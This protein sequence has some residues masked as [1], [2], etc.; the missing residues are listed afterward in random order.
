MSVKT[1]LDMA[2]QELGY[3]GKISDSQLDNFT[4][5][6]RGKYTKYGAEYGSYFNQRSSFINSDWCHS[7]VSYLARHTGQAD[8]T[9]QHSAV[10]YTA[11]CPTGF[12]WFRQRGRGH[13]RTS[14]YT[15]VEGDIAYFTWSGIWKR[16]DG[17]YNSDHVGI[18]TK[19]AN[20]QVTTA[21]GNTNNSMSM[22]KIRPINSTDFLGFGHPDYLND[23]GGDEDMTLDQFKALYNQMTDEW[24]D[25]DAEPY[26]AEARKWAIDNGIFAGIGNLPD[27]TPN[28]AWGDLVTREQAVT[29]AYRIVNNIK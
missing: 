2:K 5:N 8:I 18:I 23:D 22:E 3:Y 14:G 24:R 9:G 6:Q 19:V 15:P 4:A 27:G 16:S 17:R 13:L 1:I 29:I 28:Y 25:N 21:E 11:S 12:E 20:G 26:S 7:W 10:P